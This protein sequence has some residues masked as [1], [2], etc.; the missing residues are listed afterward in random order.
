MTLRVILPS[1]V[2]KNVV[3]PLHSQTACV[4]EPLAPQKNDLYFR[5]C[6]TDAIFLIFKRVT[7]QQVP[8]V[9]QADYLLEFL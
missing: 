8:L 4:K 1:A 6:R 5:H 3:A 7:K 9:I 2:L